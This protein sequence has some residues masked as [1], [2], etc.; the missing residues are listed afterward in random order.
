MKAKSPNQILREKRG[1]FIRYHSGMNE[2]DSF[3]TNVLQKEGYSAKPLN[4]AN[5]Q[6]INVK[7]VV[8]D[9]VS[10]KLN[11]F[12]FKIRNGKPANSDDL[13]NDIHYLKTLQAVY[14]YFKPLLISRTTPECTATSAHNDNDIFVNEKAK[15]KKV[16]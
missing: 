2:I 12:K 5:D 13:N 9:K 10:G 11:Q 6:Q 4:E 7:Q 3:D 16:A 15:D 8:A 1:V 14:P